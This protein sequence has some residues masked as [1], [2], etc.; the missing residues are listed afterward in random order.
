MQIVELVRSMLRE[1]NITGISVDSNNVSTSNHDLEC[2][3][4]TIRLLQKT[5]EKRLETRI[6][7]D[8]GKLTGTSD[9][10]Q[11]LETTRCD[12]FNRITSDTV[13]IRMLATRSQ[14]AVNNAA[15]LIIEE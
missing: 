14:I 12:K 13:F 15:S 1:L 5:Q 2:V 11:V 9:K 6:T 10:R 7:T 8:K 3:M 4:R